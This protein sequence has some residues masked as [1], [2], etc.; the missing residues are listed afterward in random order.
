MVDAM[1]DVMRLVIVH[2][3][4]AHEGTPDEDSQALEE[5]HE[6]EP[7]ASCGWLWQRDH[8]GITL[9]GCVGRTD[10]SRRIFI[11]HGMIRKVRYVGSKKVIDP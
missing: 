9:V 7:V 10:Y 3:Y 5:L 8:T 2:W 6:P 4:D 11:P 1:S